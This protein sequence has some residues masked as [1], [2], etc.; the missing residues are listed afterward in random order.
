MKASRRGLY[1]ILVTEALAPG[2]REI[3]GGLEARTGE[4]RVAEAA[5]RGASSMC[6]RRS[7]ASPRRGSMIST[8]AISTW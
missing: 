1:E 7:R 4:L 3:D 2:L 5:D 6:L 8:R